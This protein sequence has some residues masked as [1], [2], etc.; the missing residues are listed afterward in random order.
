MGNIGIKLI[1]SLLLITAANIAIAQEAP[2]QIILSTINKFDGQYVCPEGT[3]PMIQDS[4]DA[5]LHKQGNSNPSDDAVTKAMYTIFPCPISPYVD[6]VT[7]HYRPASAKDIEGTWLYPETSQKLR[8]GPKSANW[9]KIKALPI[10]CEAVAYHADGVVLHAQT[11]G[12]MAC[13][14]SSAKDLENA[15]RAYPKVESWK[16]IG[17]GRMKISRTDVQNHIEEWEVLVVITPHERHGVKFNAGDLVA[18]LRREKGNEY[19][20]A[21]LFWHLQRLP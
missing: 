20:V 5:Y 19:N 11:A 16:M 10:K 17:D 4:I 9:S 3:L 7:G 21:T 14:F 2:I 1:T 18:Y 6:Y 12:N 15:F 13:Q 8:F